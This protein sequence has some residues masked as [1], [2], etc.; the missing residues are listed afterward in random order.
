[1]GEG[2]RVTVLAW[3]GS[4]LRFR[5]HLV[6]VCPNRLQWRLG[7]CL[8]LLLGAGGILEAHRAEP[9]ATEFALPFQPKSGNWKL[10]YEYA[11][12]RMGASE[13]TVPEVEVEL[14]IAPR[15]QINAGFPVLRLR[16][17]REEPATVTGGKLELGGR[18]LLFG[19]ATRKYA[20]SFQGTVETPTGNRRVVG[21]A[22]ELGAGLFADR[23]LSDRLRVH[24]NIGWQTTVRWCGAPIRT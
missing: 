1:M 15:L 11:R 14:G 3:A 13:H 10:V 20:V 19:G 8:F 22:A 6:R 24:S 16:E 21:D 12:K 23:Y 2:R 7:A 17:G 18:Y 9:I 4:R 5:S